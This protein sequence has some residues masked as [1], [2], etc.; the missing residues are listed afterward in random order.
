EIPLNVLAQDDFSIT[1]ITIQT[2]TDN[3]DD[4]EWKSF[5]E[6]KNEST[7][8]SF[9]ASYALNLD[10]YSD[11]KIY[12]RAF[13]ADSAGNVGEPSA[14]YE[15]IVDKTAPKALTSLE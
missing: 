7:G 4:A 1:S 15:Y 11:G 14:I 5:A 9:A 6:I 8:N 3:G 10:N 12:V 13:A 2:S